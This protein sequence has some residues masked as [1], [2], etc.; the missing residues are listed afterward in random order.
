MKNRNIWIAMTI[1]SLLSVTCA[2]A[3]EEVLLFDSWWSGDYAKN[4]CN[5][6]KIE[7]SDC[8]AKEECAES[9]SIVST[10]NLELPK[11]QAK[12]FEYEIISDMESNKDCRNIR[13]SNDINNYQWM[14]MI[15]FIPSKSTQSG[16]LKHPKSYNMSQVSGTASEI[17]SKICIIVN[18][19]GAVK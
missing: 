14:L 5:L 6:A 4:A 1:W 3:A 2:Y 8:K 17:A 19:M 16:D 7:T 12:R 9:L 18:G 13:I 10:C 11:N 15:D